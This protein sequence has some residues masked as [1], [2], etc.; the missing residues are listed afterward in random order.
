MADLVFWEHRLEG[1]PGSM[2]P[3]AI[4]L[5]SQRS[6]AWLLRVPPS[7][8]SAVVIVPFLRVVL[9]SLPPVF[10]W[11]FFFFFFS[12]ILCFSFSSS[13]CLRSN[14]SVLSPPPQQD[15]APAAAQD[16]G[17]GDCEALSFQ[18]VLQV[19]LTPE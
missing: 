4:M 18:Q 11:T 9:T 3:F 15:C 17:G 1:E 10:P 2:K 8:V 16:L 14:L 19:I 12:F 7:S 6:H 13:L 5:H